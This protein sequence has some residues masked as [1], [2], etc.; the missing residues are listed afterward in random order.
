M[1][2][3][4][5]ALGVGVS[6]SLASQP[7]PVALAQSQGG[8]QFVEYAGM[9]EVGRVLAEVQRLKDTGTPVLFHPSYIN[10]CGSFPNSP[11]WLAVT[12]EHIR[13]VGSPWFAQ[14]CAYCFWD[15]GFGYST[16][17]G[18]FIPPIFNQASL[19]KAVERVAEVQACMP[20]PVAIEPPPLVFAAGNMP[21]FTFFGE[22]AERADCAILLDMGH[23]V[24]WQMATGQK[25]ADA[26]SDLPAGR[27]VELHIAGGKLQKGILGEMY[28]DAHECAILPQS[29]AMLESLLP[30]LPEVRAVCFACEG[31][32]AEAVMQTLRRLRQLVLSRSASA[33]LVARTR[34]V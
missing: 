1:I 33:A 32:T 8:P 11:D 19:D 20:V 12:A 5:D 30:L 21:L 26:I 15:Q 18:Y 34:Q 25:V 31:S 14:D 16:Q 6:L 23:L 4:L 27:V 13:A 24:S 9:A 3:E 7:D 29:W 22:L 2:P 10:F 28:V 17:L